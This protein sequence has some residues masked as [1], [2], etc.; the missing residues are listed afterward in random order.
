MSSAWGNRMREDVGIIE[1]T[2][3]ALVQ[4]NLRYLPID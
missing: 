4:E 1:T 3:N 2:K